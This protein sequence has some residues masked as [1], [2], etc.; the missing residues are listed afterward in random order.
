V[1]RAALPLLI[2]ATAALAAWQLE[3][4]EANR[5]AARVIAR[6]E[7]TA[8]ALQQRLGAY[9]DVLFGVRGL[10]E[11]STDVTRREFHAQLAAVD[12]NRR[13]PGVLAVGVAELV[14]TDDTTGF[15]ARV[16]RDMQRSGLPY[17]RFSIRGRTALERRLVIDYLEPQRGNGPAIGFD[18]LSEPA[19]RRAAERALETGAATATAPL[20]LLSESPATPGL[21]IFL[22]VRARFLTGIAYAA[23]RVDDL[24][25]NVRSPD[26]PANLLLE[27]IGPGAGGSVSDPARRI[28]TYRNGPVGDGATSIAFDVL[29][30]RWELHYVARDAVISAGEEIVPWI[31]LGSGLLLAGLAAWLLSATAR[32]ERRALALAT[33]MTSDLRDKEA[34]LQRS[35]AELERFAYVASH[36]LREPLRSITGFISL[37][38][39][40]HGPALDEDARSWIGYALD[41]ADRM[42]ALIADLLEYSRAGR[43]L[44]PGEAVSADLQAAWDQAV[45]G[46]AAAIEES[47]ATVTSDPLPT[48]AAEQREINQ[49]MQNLLG[50]AIKYRGDRA[51]VVHAGAERRDGSWAVSVQDNGIGIDGQHRDRIFVLFQRLHTR[52]DYEGTGMGL[53][54]V[55]KIVEARGG[56]IAVDS[57][58]GQGSRF[59]VVLPEAAD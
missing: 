52:D 43:R 15:V 48:V 27:D 51:P 47:G 45:A 4:A 17:E 53:S 10:F 39:R 3:R 19:R 50:N 16:R 32:T 11:A 12:V 29:G 46:L 58:P 37:L 31:V 25:R 54:I 9:T 28:V 26:E 13:Y 55:K 23:L 42:N 14:P 8:T 1:A 59:T 49:V 33:R 30:R 36:D 21:L 24:V 6:A 56:S 5:R 7:S 34:E 41:G 44:D 35:N 38:A 20:G 18:L 40:R 22:P 57:T 2:A